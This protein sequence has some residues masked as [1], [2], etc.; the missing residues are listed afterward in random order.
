MVNENNNYYN[1]EKTEM[2][3][4]QMRFILRGFCPSLVSTHTETKHVRLLVVKSS[5]DYALT[6]PFMGIV[7]KALIKKSAC[8]REI[9]YQRHRTSFI[10]YLKIHY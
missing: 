6:F 1:Y 2:L 8:Y 4:P 7:V 9:S 5:H 10:T 3:I